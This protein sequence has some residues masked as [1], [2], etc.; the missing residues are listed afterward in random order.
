MVFCSEDDV[1]EFFRSVPEFERMLVRSGIRL[2]KYWFS[3]SDSEQEQRFRE[4]I[5][6][7]MRRRQLGSA[8]EKRVRDDFPFAR[9]C[10]ALYQL[11]RSCLSQ[12]TPP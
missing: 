4:R 3:V 11:L 7:P 6:D 12:P 8:A 9:G 5:A 2:L 1:E 10:K